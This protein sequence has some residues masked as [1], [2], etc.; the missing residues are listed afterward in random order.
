MKRIGRFWNFQRDATV[1]EKLKVRLHL[2]RRRS[3]PHFP[4]PPN[5]S[6]VFAIKCTPPFGKLSFAGRGSRES[7]SIF[8]FPDPE[9]SIRLLMERLA[10]PL[11]FSVWSSTWTVPDVITWEMFF[12]LCSAVARRS[13]KQKKKEQKTKSINK[14]LM[15][16]NKN[17]KNV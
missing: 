10:R 1:R 3:H 5:V 4:Q 13:N 8:S 7:W 9:A 11:P 6:P 14:W 16:F 12:P 17:K 2:W 15:K